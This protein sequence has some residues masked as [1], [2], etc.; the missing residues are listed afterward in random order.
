MEE[1]AGRSGGKSRKVSPLAQLILG[2]L[3]RLSTLVPLLTVQ[4]TLQGL[5]WDICSGARV[6]GQQ[7]GHTSNL[8][9]I[10]PSKMVP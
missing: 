4:I 10:P 6:T 2:G 7:V 9:L 1:A 8:G 3:L 5:T